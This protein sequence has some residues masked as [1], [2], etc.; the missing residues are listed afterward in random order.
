M[1]R[2][3]ENAFHVLGLKTT[4][5]RADAEREGQKLLG[6]LELGLHQ[7]TSY[8][9]PLGER[10]RT[11]ELIRWALAELRD[12]EKRMMHELL[13]QLDAEATLPPAPVSSEDTH[14][15]GGLDSARAMLGW[16][17]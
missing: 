6:M 14:G 7:A 1:Q 5:S 11:A 4:A 12:P 3:T 2:L 15:P 8:V 16:G 17:R 10:E 13:A 9:T